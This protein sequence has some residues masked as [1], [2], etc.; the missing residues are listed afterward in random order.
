MYFYVSVFERNF[1]SSRRNGSDIINKH[2]SKFR[3][4]V[5]GSVEGGHRSGC[6]W[7][8]DGSTRAILFANCVEIE[9][10][11]CGCNGSGCSGRCSTT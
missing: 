5:D 1:D 10:D 6:S 8:E 4:N 3:C 11:G 9:D 7:Y 2:H